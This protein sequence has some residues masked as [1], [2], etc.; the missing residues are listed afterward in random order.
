MSPISES[1]KAPE[2]KVM[3]M[4]GKTDANDKKSSNV[5]DLFKKEKLKKVGWLVILFATFR[6]IGKHVFLI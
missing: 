4:K 3:S 2:G 1:K 5:L 6:L